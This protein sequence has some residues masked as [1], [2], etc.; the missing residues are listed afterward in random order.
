M[1]KHFEPT[2]QQMCRD[3]Q[4]AF[5]AIAGMIGSKRGG[6]VI[7]NAPGGSNKTFLLNLLLTFVRKEKDMAVTIASSSIVITLLAGGRT[8]HS[9]FKLP[10]DLARSDCAT[11]NISKGTGQGRSQI[12]QANFPG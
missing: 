5:I 10:L 2:W 6:I 1:F 12:L 9:A 4:Q 7:L 3:L 8:A 11:C